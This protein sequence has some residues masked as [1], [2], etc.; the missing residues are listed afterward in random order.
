MPPYDQIY[1]SAFLCEKVLKEESGVTSA[2]RMVDRHLVSLSV[3][4]EKPET[5]IAEFLK[6]HPPTYRVE[7]FFFVI[8]K[9]EQPK[10][11]TA[12]IRGETPTGKEFAKKE[13]PDIELRGAPFG[14][15]LILE[16]ALAVQTQGIYWFEVLVGDDLRHRTPL[17][18]V[19]TQSVTRDNQQSTLTADK[20]ES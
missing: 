19:I 10:K 2:I 5:E 4:A 15:S 7:G 18:V 9:S 8:F 16:F 14:H 3:T 17:E 11:F 12:W 6:Q 13:F 1:I 20:N